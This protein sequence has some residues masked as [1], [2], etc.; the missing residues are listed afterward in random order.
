MYTE[1]EIQSQNLEGILSGCELV[2]SKQAWCLVEKE[3]S[4]KKEHSFPTKFT[5]SIR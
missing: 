4:V 3:M 5:K 2:C 1:E